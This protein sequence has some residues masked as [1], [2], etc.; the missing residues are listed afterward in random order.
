MPPN[1][2][3]E[4]AGAAGAA[5]GFTL[6]AGYV[7][8]LMVWTRRIML[9]KISMA[10]NFIIGLC[11]VVVYVVYV[12]GMYTFLA[13]FYDSQNLTVMALMLTFFICLMCGLFV[14]VVLWMFNGCALM[15]PSCMNS[16]DFRSDWR[17]RLSVPWNA[18]LLCNLCK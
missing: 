15:C 18:M 2:R 13:A 12:S 6:A 1:R 11:L 3:A 7:A 5:L 14:F 4:E 10:I 8:T 17:Y 9:S 16:G